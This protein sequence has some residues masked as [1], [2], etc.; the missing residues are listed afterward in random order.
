MKR[1]LVLA[2]VV[3]CT[4]QALPPLAEAVVVVDTDL[5][6]PRVAAALRVDTYAEDG[7]WLESRDID[8]PDPRDW[9]VSFSVQAADD[10]K[11]RNVLVRLRAHRG[12]GRD[13]VGGPR[14]V[15]K[16]VDVTPTTEPVPALT[17]DR[18]LVVRLVAGTRGRVSV[19]LR[20]SCAGVSASVQDRTTCVDGNVVVAAPVKLG[21]DLTLPSESAAGTALAA[22]CPAALPNGRVCVE[23]GVSVLGTDDV[24]V[25]PDPDLSATPAR[26]VRISTFA[27]DDREVSVGRFRAAVASGFAPPEMPRANEGALG[28]T[29]DSA[30]TWSA[31][32]IGREDF[33]MTCISWATSR[34]FCKYANGDLPAEAAWEHAATSAHRTGK[35][36][37]PWGD[38]APDCVRA[39]YGRLTLASLPGACEKAAGSGPRP[40]VEGGVLVAPGDVS[41]AGVHDLGGNVAEW[42]RTAPV[43]YDALCFGGVDPTCDDDGASAHVVRGGSWASPPIVVRST[44]RLSASQPASFIGFRCAYPIGAP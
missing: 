30:C 25:V 16:G 14:L 37:F 27:L 4:T 20:A 36:A 5:P 32:A 34:A 44:A 7:T 18:L 2:A 28:T 38:D 10:S 22:P 40:L 3:S 17:V 21:P 26:L 41:T 13:V 35:V 1:V 11:D 33:A 8:R 29:P 24:D 6:V 39:V 42:M 19:T 9:P 12:Q 43:A 23:G 15:S 31:T